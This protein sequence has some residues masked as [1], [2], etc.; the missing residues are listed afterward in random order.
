MAGLTLRYD[1]Q[2]GGAVPSIRSSASAA[3]SSASAS[4]RAR[5]IGVLTW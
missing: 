2:N 3:S 1:A 5:D 4:G